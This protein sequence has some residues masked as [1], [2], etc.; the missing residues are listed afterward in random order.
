MSKPNGYYRKGCLWGFDG[1][2]IAIGIED[3]AFFFGSLS[4]TKKAACA[5]H[6]LNTKNV[7]WINMSKL[8]GKESY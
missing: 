8:Y 2:Y 3:E 1:Y 7:N 5:N 4:E 6:Y